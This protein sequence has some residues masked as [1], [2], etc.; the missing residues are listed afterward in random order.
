VTADLAQAHRVL[1]SVFGYDAFRGRQADVIAHLLDGGDAL[2]LMPTGGGKSLCYQVPALV[3]D[4]MGVVISPLIAL[5]QNQ[6]DRL[7][8]L[9]VRAAFLNSTLAPADA[10]AVVRRVLRRELDVLYLAPER[11][12]LPDTLAMLERVPLSL[13]AVDEAHCISQWGHDFRKD[14]LGL[15]VLGE[16]FPEVP[17][18]ALTATANPRTRE[19]IVERLGLRRSRTFVSSFNRPNIFYRVATKAKARDQLLAFLA[20]QPE[21]ATGI[22]YCQ[23]RA[24]VEKVAELLEGRGFDALPYH[25]GLPASTRE[26]NLARFLRDDGVVVVATIAFGMG[27]DK[28][29]V[30]FV[31]HL[32]LPKNLEAYYQETGRAGRDGEPAVAWMTY[33]MQD[34][35]M[36]RQMVSQA[37]MDE[38]VKR[39]ELQKIQALL[40]FCETTTCRRQILLRYFGEE[41]T[42]ACGACDTCTTPVATWDGTVAAQKALSCVYRTQQRFGVQHL[43]DVLLGQRTERIAALRH[44]QVSTFGIGTEHDERTWRSVFRQLV[45]RGLVTVD[46]FGALKLAK[47]ASGVLTG[48]ERLALRIDE[49][50]APRERARRKRTRDRRERAGATAAK[51]RLVG[52][53]ASLLAALSQHRSSLARASGL[54]A[55]MIFQNTTLEAMAQARPGTLGEMRGISGVG[56]AK[57]AKYGDSF[58]AVIREHAGA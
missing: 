36:L 26:R 43:I 45:A 51:G 14:Y 33:G 29:D 38:R 13:F 57:L 3:R 12:V 22:V 50:P 21:G 27:I 7:V 39:V 20:E 34:A 46:E 44:D 11:L 17:R 55:Y 32:D 15:S 31:A 37:D 25:A 30:R 47:A 10:A 24:S 2:V 53:D 52:G 6:V 16:R 40:G 54:P 56:D 5:M 58:L 4:G 8:E 35:V 28:P 1:K 19:E 9:G 41:D 42:P 18:V 23:T 49:S 48:G